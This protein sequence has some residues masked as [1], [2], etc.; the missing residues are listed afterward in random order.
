MDPQATFQ[1]WVDAVTQGKTKEARRHA[2]DYHDWTRRGGFCAT[3]DDGMIIQ[4]L[5]TS[6]ALYV[7][8]LDSGKRQTRK[9]ENG[10]AI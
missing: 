1:L 7:V 9:A 6:T 4:S 8:D 10:E 3:D 5:H 2:R